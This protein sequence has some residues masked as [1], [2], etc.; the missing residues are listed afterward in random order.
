MKKCCICSKTIEREDAPV[1]TMG[2]F[3]NPRYLCDECAA[4]LDKAMFSHEPEEIEGAIE[5]L[6]KNMSDMSEADS[7]SFNALYSLLSISGS[8]LKEIKEGTYD[9]SIDEKIQNAQNDDSF[10]E[11]P[12]E[13]QE[14][15]E[16]KALDERDAEKQKKFDQFTNWVAIG[17]I[18]ATIGF[19]IYKLFS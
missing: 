11:I 3:G 9:F 8:R 5:K 6:G 17:A 7:Q 14:T 16:D 2:A 19:I 1:L 12:E 15:E 10:V 13:L 18:I 4:D